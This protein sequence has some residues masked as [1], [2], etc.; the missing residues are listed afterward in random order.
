MHFKFNISILIFLAIVI[1]SFKKN[2]KLIRSG[3]FKN[4]EICQQHL[5]SENLI[6]KWIMNGDPETYIN[7][8]ENGVAV[9]KSLGDP[10]K[11]YWLIK[12]NKLCLKAT[13][14]QNNKEICIDYELDEDELVLTMNDMKLYYI[15]SRE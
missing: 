15:R 1:T 5:E 10:L 2:P 12:G 9:E 13:S 11:R 7:L 6:G 3:E 8:G 4:K 14:V